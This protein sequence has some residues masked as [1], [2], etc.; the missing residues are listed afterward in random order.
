[1][2]LISGGR[3]RDQ[4]RSDVNALNGWKKKKTIADD[5]GMS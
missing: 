5:S 4:L 1:M 3:C 2:L